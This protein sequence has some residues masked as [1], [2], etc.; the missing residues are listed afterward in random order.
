MDRFVYI[1]NGEDDAYVNSASNFVGMEQASSGAVL[2]RFKAAA[3]AAGNNAGFDLITLGV[4]ANSEKEAMV[5]I[6][7][8]LAGGKAGSTAV[9]ADDH[10]SKYCDDTVTGVTSIAKNTLGNNTVEL[11]DWT[12]TTVLTS[13]D[14]GKMINASNAG[15]K[16]L[17]LPAATAGEFFEIKISV[18]QTGATRIIVPSGYFIGN[19]F[20]EEHGTAT[21]NTHSFASNGSS[22]DY[23]NLDGDTKGRL[24]GGTIRIVCDGTN[25]LI[26]GRLSG[27]GTLATPFADS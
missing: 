5:A 3:G 11:I 7:G 25:W 14:S 20:L 23:I 15:A 8:A 17:T 4:T 13:A 9:I 16:D 22:N 1:R 12:A 21:E 24:A 27:S 10:G 18:A 26:D 6:A 19:L 2:L